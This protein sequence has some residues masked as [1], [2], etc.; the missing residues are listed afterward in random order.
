MNRTITNNIL[1][2]LVLIS[3]LSSSLTMAS[4][5]T[6]TEKNSTSDQTGSGFN[7]GDGQT[8]FFMLQS[9]LQTLGLDISYGDEG[10]TLFSMIDY[11]LSKIIRDL[12]SGNASG[13][14]DNPLINETFQYFGINESDIIINP[15]D[16]SGEMEATRSY[17]K[18][19]KD[20]ETL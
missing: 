7:N 16:V 19:G 3:V 20:V 10:K 2:L 9:L 4:D 14:K 15:E 6:I 8:G 12:S 17:Y 1:I 11:S 5:T 13:V 18:M